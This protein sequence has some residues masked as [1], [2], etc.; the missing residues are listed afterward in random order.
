MTADALL[1][2]R[3]RLERLLGQ[4]G[5]GEVHLSHDAMLERR[6]AIKML[7]AALEHDA[8][9]RQRFRREALAAAALDHPFICKIYEVGEDAG[10]SFIAMEYVEGRTL[11]ARDVG[12]LAGRH[13]HPRP[14]T[15]R[16]SRGANARSQLRLS[17]EL[18]R[19]TPSPR[20]PA[21]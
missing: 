21:G 13:A 6:V 4:G 16:R 11:D 9:S 20:A 10:R 3:Y 14:D 7:P 2:G 1:G 19:P 8:Q 15:S 12:P 17:P 5:M 18:L